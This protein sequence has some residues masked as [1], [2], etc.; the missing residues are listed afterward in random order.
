MKF[1]ENAFGPIRAVPP[2]GKDGKKL[3]LRTHVVAIRN[4]FG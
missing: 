4:C 3:T 1:R 2:E